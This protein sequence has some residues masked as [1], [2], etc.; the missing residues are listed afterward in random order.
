M[1]CRVYSE[2]GA[3]GY[4]FLISW[5][6][7]GTAEAA[8]NPGAIYVEP[9]FG[10]VSYGSFVSVDKLVHK[11]D[12]AKFVLVFAGLDTGQGVVHL[13]GQFAHISAT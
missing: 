3:R 9:E 7:G 13:L 2:Y 10:A 4:L 11:L 12:P 6:V 8:P 5:C 1:I